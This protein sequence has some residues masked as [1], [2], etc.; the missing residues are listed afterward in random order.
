MFILYYT[1]FKIIKFLQIKN[2]TG[3]KYFKYISLKEVIHFIFL[4]L[5]YLL[6]LKILYPN[7]TKPIKIAK[8]AKIK[9][10]L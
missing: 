8:N 5:G 4:K 3:L 2:R 6:S 7:K 1:N 10:L 9:T